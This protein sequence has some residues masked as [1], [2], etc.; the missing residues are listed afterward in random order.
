MLGVAYLS[1][2]WLKFCCV[3]CIG[4]G[5]GAVWPMYA[6]AAIDYFPKSIAGSVIGVW[7]VFLGVGSILSPVICGWTIDFF[8]NFA[9]TFNLGLA[10]GLAAA[11]C[12]VP[13]LD[14][15]HTGSVTIAPERR[16]ICGR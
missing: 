15:F 6:A 5:F 16:E 2:L 13:L 12:L 4:L 3:G 9:W 14:C 7:T 11:V 1:E 10:G 8:G